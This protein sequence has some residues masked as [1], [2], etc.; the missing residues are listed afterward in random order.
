MIAILN[1]KLLNIEE[2]IVL[3]QIKAIASSNFLTGREYKQQYLDF[4]RIEQ[5]RS[6]I[7]TK[8]RIQPFCR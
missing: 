8:A 4:I 7:M 2:I 1:I 3:F 6:K 5:R